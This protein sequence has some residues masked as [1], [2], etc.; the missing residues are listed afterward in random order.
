MAGNRHEHHHGVKHGSGHT[1][2]TKGK[3]EAEVR[4][5]RASGGKLE[6]EGKDEAEADLK[7]EPE[8]RTNAKKIDGEAHA[9]KAKRGGK[10]KKMVKMEGKEAHHHAGRK[11]RKSGGAASETNPFTTANKGERR[12]GGMLEKESMGK[13]A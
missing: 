1:H 3:I 9:M 10:I 8:E 6:E 4:K 11:A 13:D 5:H 12:P 2:G 7:D